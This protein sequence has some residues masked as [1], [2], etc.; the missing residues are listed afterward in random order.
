MVL[1]GYSRHKPQGVCTDWNW[2]DAYKIH[3]GFTHTLMSHVCHCILFFEFCE[4]KSQI[5]RVWFEPTTFAILKQCRQYCYARLEFILLVKFDVANL[6]LGR[7]A[8]L[9][10]CK[11]LAP[12]HRLFCRNSFR[13][14]RKYKADFSVLGWMS[15]L[16]LRSYDVALAINSHNSSWVQLNL[17]T[18]TLWKY[19]SSNLY[20]GFLR[21]W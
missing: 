10:W 12:K 20:K 9:N 17:S 6:Q 8:V 11:T 1:V 7:E 16:W 13:T 14:C 18:L 15:W 19:D 3:F 2:W 4:K 5:T 21:K